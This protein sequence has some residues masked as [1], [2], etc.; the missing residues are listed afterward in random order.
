MSKHK[1][2]PMTCRPANV[3]EILDLRARVLRSGKP[4]EAARFPEDEYELTLHFGAFIEEKPVSCLTLI[5]NAEPEIPT[6]QL[7]GMATDPEWQRKGVG[8]TLLN[9]TEQYLCKHYPRFRI[10]C[11][12][13][14]HASAFYTGKGYRV[15][16]EPFDIEHIGPHYKMEKYFL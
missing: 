7:R 3:R 4:L 12:V 1:P 13:R 5:A 9:Y 16:S 14:V 10:W 15:I 6:W 11:N 2:E 8:S